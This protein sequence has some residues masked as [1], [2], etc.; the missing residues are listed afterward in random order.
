MRNCQSTTAGKP[1]GTS[2]TA[3]ARDPKVAHIAIVGLSDFH[4][5]DRT[6]DAH[7]GTLVA[8]QP[9]GAPSWFPCNDR[10][11]DKAEFVFR[12]TVPRG[13]HALANGTLAEHRADGAP[14]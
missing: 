4:G 13:H 3:A 6:G 14:N 10:P 11:D 9:L 12:I 7:G 2:S 8:A 5:W 1:S